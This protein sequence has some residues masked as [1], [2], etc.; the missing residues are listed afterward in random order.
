MTQCLSRSDK[1]KATKKLKS[2]R[3]WQNEIQEYLDPPKPLN[4]TLGLFFGGYFLASPGGPHELKANIAIT[5]KTN[6]A[7]LLKLN[8]NFQN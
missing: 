7:E 3:D 5:K 2:L 1:N 4:V 8:I 6:I